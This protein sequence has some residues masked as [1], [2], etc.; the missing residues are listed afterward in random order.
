MAK[1][2]EMSKKITWMKS[3]LAKL[4]HMHKIEERAEKERQR[5]E[6]AKNRKKKPDVAPVSE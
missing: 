5:Q 3:F 4:G 1:K 6:A 2:A